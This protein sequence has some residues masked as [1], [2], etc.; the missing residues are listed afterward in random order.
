VRERERRM[1]GCL[2]TASGP[3]ARVL[4]RGRR[5][6]APSQ[7]RRG[8]GAALA[9]LRPGPTCLGLERRRKRMAQGWAAVAAK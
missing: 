3:G 9:G 8:K 7:M 4:G 2:A 1:L 5:R 6:M